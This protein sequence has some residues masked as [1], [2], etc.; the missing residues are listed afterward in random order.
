MAILF[1]L[2]SLSYS[3]TSIVAA[4]TLGSYARTS[5]GTAQALVSYGRDAAQVPESYVC[6]RSQTLGLYVTVCLS[7][8]QHLHVTVKSHFA[9]NNVDVAHGSVSNILP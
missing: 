6:R 1:K 5:V 3:C 9:A 2:S 4:Q 8:L 7:V